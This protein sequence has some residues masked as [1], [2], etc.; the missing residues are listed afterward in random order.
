MLSYRAFSLGYAGLLSRA[1]RL[2][3]YCVFTA[4][5]LVLAQDQYEPNDERGTAT[6]LIVGDP[7][8]QMHTLDPDQDIDWFRFN[9]RY[10]EIYDI[11]TL[12]VG[13]QVD[14]VLEVYNEI[15]DKI[16]EFDFGFLGEGEAFSFRAKETGTYYLKIYDYN[17]INQADDCAEPRGEAA[18]YSVAIFV[19]IGAAA[20]P[21]LSIVQQQGS[22][23]AVGRAFPLGITVKNNGG[24]TEDDTA[25]N[26]VILTYSEPKLPAPTNLPEG[27][28]AGRG[29]DSDGFIVDQPGLVICL[30]DQLVAEESFSYTLNFEFTEVGKVRFTSAV[31]GHEDENYTLRQ[32]DDRWSNNEI[33]EVVNVGEGSGNEPTDSDGDGIVDGD[34]NCSLVINVNQ[35]DTDSDGDGDACDS[36][37][38]NDEVA[39]SD[40]NCPL[41]VNA[42][43]TDTDSDG[44]GDAC[45]SDDD[46]DDV[47]DG[48]D[49]CP[50]IANSS[51][52]DAD[53]D[54]VGDVC[55][56]SNDA[57]S[58]S[59]GVLDDSDNCPAIKNADQEDADGDGLGDLC[60]D[61]L[62]GD[63]VDNGADNCP[64]VE[65]P[66][67]ADLDED[68]VGDA[69][70]L[71]IDGDKVAD[72][73]DNCPVT[74]N[75]NQSDIDND[76]DGD[77]CDNDDDGD[78]IEDAV[79]NCPAIANADQ[80]DSD[81]DG[82]GDAC[83]DADL[84]DQDDDGVSDDLDNCP[85]IANADQADSDSDG[86]G[87]A[88][89]DK[90][91]DGDNDGIDDGFDNCP[92]ID[93]PD[94]DDFDDDGE[95]D[96]C[97]NDL[98][99]D[100]IS[101]AA[102]LFPKDSRGGLDSDLDGLP[103]QWEAL[104]GL[105]PEDSR[106][107]A[108]DADNDGA[109]A[110]QE[111]LRDTDPTKSDLAQQFLDFES[112]SFLVTGQST[113]I[114]L[115]YN[116]SDDN[117]SVDRLAFQLFYQSDALGGDLL[118]DM[119]VF[120]ESA[121]ASGEEVFADVDDLD[122][123]PATDV[124][125][126]FEW[127]DGEGDWPGE[128][129]LPLTLLSGTVTPAESLTA[130]V[131]NLMPIQAATGYEIK[132]SSLRLSIGS[133]SLDIDGDGEAKPLTDGLLVIRYLFGFRGASLT[134]GAVGAEA[135]R[136]DPE[137]IAT[138]V[139]A[140]VP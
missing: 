70:D 80:A 131:L 67:Q 112:P 98:D 77:A 9:A 28:A 128:G 96:V 31:A 14:L 120:A 88:C 90:P 92:L 81:S 54:G 72:A 51:Q 27:C 16:E 82:K 68:G 6:Q 50:L 1:I 78:Q 104:Y 86:K 26:L 134:S 59:D 140:L 63:E 44:E 119:Q 126:Y 121:L 45:D 43:Q 100:G 138:A 61:D 62:D 4:P 105:N 118:E 58:D 34:D 19:P 13:D 38:D 109:S 102:D 94:Q 137:D 17:C 25:K 136:M 124:Y 66:D 7:T 117:P 89:D 73:V 53:Q 133:V 30:K 107:A 29:P 97:D 36:D 127:S 11:R 64:T 12:E 40:D 15:G 132:A 106:D 52:A 60:D 41:V 110:L 135:T 42:N 101:N 116:T 84:V 2:C 21:D 37:D 75:S 5:L 23:P 48:V 10:D 87:D 22:D 103:D 114:A 47:S 39:D 83:D 71:D 139:E 111:F 56:G 3:A 123:N 46:N 65:N 74:P 69:C 57:D 93:N 108:S 24:Q 99:G 55:D 35:T 115:I 122:D 76:G 85:A 130:F 20:G 91:Q 113:S 129:E 8:P 18:K 125:R 79:D 32:S 33:S 49:N 95:G